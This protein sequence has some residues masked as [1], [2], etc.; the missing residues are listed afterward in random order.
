M[1]AV[2]GAADDLIQLAEVTSGSPPSWAAEVGAVRARGEATSRSQLAITGTDLLALGIPAG[3]E[4]GRLL[5]RLLETVIEDPTR[6]TREGLL[7]L[8]GTL[9]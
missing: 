4:L 8:A 9:R 3:P 6:N 7:A 5:T 2:E 1:A